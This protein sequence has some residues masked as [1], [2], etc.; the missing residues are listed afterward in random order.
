MLDTQKLFWKKTE[1]IHVVNTGEVLFDANN[2]TIKKH[3]QASIQ[4][5]L[6][7]EKN[8]LHIILEEGAEVDLVC[9]HSS[10][11]EEKIEANIVIQHK[12]KNSTSSMSIKGVA[13]EKSSL[14]LT[15]EII[16]DEKAQ[17]AEGYQHINILMIG[18]EAE[19]KATPK[20]SINN[21]EVICSH[22]ASVGGIDEEQL[23][24]LQ[25]RGLSKEEAEKSIVQGF[26][27]STGKNI[28]NK[29]LYTLLQEQI[30]K[31]E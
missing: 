21:P 3:A 23:F 11:K 7:E 10:T 5:A 15:G 28:K 16:I 25:S 24:Y 17:H 6:L 19:G 2:I 20:L 30:H 27:R 12:G 29:E 31:E 4:Y 18:E 9:T 1:N 22:G 13:K 8:N 26:L 14:T